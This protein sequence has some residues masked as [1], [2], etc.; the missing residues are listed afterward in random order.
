MAGFFVCIYSF[1]TVETMLKIIDN[2]AQLKLDLFATV[3]RFDT[4][5]V[6]YHPIPKPRQLPN[7]KL[8]EKLD[9]LAA[10]MQKTIDNKLNPAIGN[11]NITARRSRIATSMREEGER[12]ATIQ[13]WF[14]GLADSHR[15]GTCPEQFAKI[16]NR[17]QLEDFGWIHA[18]ALDNPKY[19]ENCF[20]HK[21]S[22]IDRLKAFGINSKDEA[23]AAVERLE[24]LCSGNPAPEIDRSIEQAMDLRR[25]AIYQKVPDFFPTPKGLIDRMLEIA[26]VQPGQRVLDPS[27]GAGDI[28]LAV[29]ASG[30][31]TIDCFEINWD[32]VQ[33]LA[34]LEFQ[35]LARDFLTA[36]PRPIY[37]RVVMNPPFSKDAYID[38][39]RA[40]YHWLA[41]GGELIAVLP[42]GYRDSRIAKRREFT[43]WL[44]ELRV[45]C[46]NNPA[47][48]FTKSDRSCGVQTHLIHIKR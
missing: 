14:V 17:K 27:A 30:V 44:D 39:V 6:V 11:Q 26:D 8:A 42:N 22:I 16:F 47:D 34:L 35:L 40:A 19:L 48:A 31:S 43:D 25:K 36:T 38:H 45:D 12:L 20:F 5:P 9:K 28:C 46:Y 13:R 37:D 18:N 1:I 21:Y 29:R 15:N 10:G 24:S 7:L 2:P 33:S 23:I 4:A 3:A 41:P 32:L